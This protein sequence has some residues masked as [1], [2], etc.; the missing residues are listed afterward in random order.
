MLVDSVCFWLGEGSS[1]LRGPLWRVL[2]GWFA[3]GISSPRSF[4]IVSRRATRSVREHMYALEM[5]LRAV[6]L[7]VTSSTPSP[8][9]KT[10]NS[11]SSLQSE[12]LLD[13]FRG[14]DAITHLLLSSSF[15]I[16]HSTPDRLHWVHSFSPGGT[17]H[18]DLSEKRRTCD[19]KSIREFGGPGMKHRRLTPC[20][21]AW[22]TFLSMRPWP[23][24]PDRA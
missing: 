23:T 11:A 20:D 8:P 19:A 9:Q 15:L 21:A 2:G 16:T 1:S 6:S 17:T 12:G 13:F 18:C 22:K 4:S 5:G 24:C 3:G 14:G 7:Y 10:L